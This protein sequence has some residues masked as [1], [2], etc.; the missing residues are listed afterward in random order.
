MIQEKAELL[1]PA[2]CVV[3]TTFLFTGFPPHWAWA[4]P[5]G[6]GKR[7]E[8]PLY[9]VLCRKLPSLESS[10]SFLPPSLSFFFVG[11]HLQR[12]E[13]PRL[14]VQLELQLPA[15]PTATATP[16]LNARSLTHR[17]SPGIE[18][19]SSETRSSS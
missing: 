8:E 2:P 16:D 10:F 7:V 6:P 13:V 1:L 11:P 5:F 15:Y 12:M 18:P 9:V 19:K 17:G 4:P 14:G 3:G